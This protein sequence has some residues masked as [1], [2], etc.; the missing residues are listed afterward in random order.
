MIH[1]DNNSLIHRNK[2]P[3]LETR[4]SPLKLSIIMLISQLV[5]ILIKEE[6]LE[7]IQL[8]DLQVH[9]LLKAVVVPFIL[10]EKA[11]IT[12]YLICFEFGY[13]QFKDVNSDIRSKKRDKYEK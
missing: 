4:K 12:I 6:L 1:L 7:A 10:N 13:T 3:P 11:S 2:K 5:V 9:L 8:V